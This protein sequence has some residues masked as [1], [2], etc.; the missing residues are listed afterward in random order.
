MRKYK[1]IQLM[2]LLTATLFI[3]QLEAQKGYAWKKLGGG[4]NNGAGCG[5]SSQIQ[6]TKYINGNLYV[7]EYT[8]QTGKVTI[9]KWNGTSWSKYPEFGFVGAYYYIKDIE[10]YNNDLYLCGDI[11]SL[12]GTKRAK[13]KNF[14]IVKFNGTNWDSLSSYYNNVID[15]VS[16]YS[17]MKVYKSKLYYI[18][19]DFQNGFKN[20][21]LVSFD[22]LTNT[23]SLVK[24]VRNTNK[25]FY[26][27]SHLEVVKNKLM[28][29]GAFDSI[30]GGV[31]TSSIFYYDGTNYSYTRNKD[32]RDI[33]RI[34]M[35]N[36]SQYVVVNSYNNKVEIW[37]D[38][39]LLKDIT[40]PIV[41]FYYYNGFTF[42]NN[43]IIAASNSVG[44]Y[45]YDLD[46]SK[47]FLNQSLNQ[48]FNLLP[49]YTYKNKALIVSCGNGFDG[50][51]EI[52]L[53]A[54]ISGKLYVDKDSSCTFNTG[55]IL[56]KHSLVEFDNGSQKFYTY[57]DKN[58]NYEI[59]LLA[60]SYNVSYS[61]PDVVST[62]A[63][64]SSISITVV[65]GTTTTNLGI[66]IHPS[67]NKNLGVA[68]SAYRGYRTRLGFT[69]KYTLTGTNFSL[70]N[71]S[72]VM[73]LKYPSS[74]TYV[75]SDV[76][77]FSNSSNEL[78]YKFANLAWLDKK[79]I[80]IEFKTTVGV[81]SLG[82]KLGFFASI[83]NGNG[84]SVPEN[85]VDTLVQTVVG[86]YD[87]NIKQCYPE[88]KVKPGLKKIKYTIHF[89]NTGNDTAY[90][91]TVVDTFT[92]K[93]GLRSLKVTNTSH[94]SSYSL[95]LGD[96]NTLIWEFNNIL[97][98]D[99]HINEKASHGFISFEANIN[100]VVALGDS[101]TNKAYIYFDY[102]TPIK[103]NVASVV[104]FNENTSVQ[105]NILQHNEFIKV[106][107]NPSFSNIN[108]IVDTKY[109]NKNVQLYNAMGQLINSTFVNDKGESQFNVSEL[110]HGIYF[111]KVEG[112]E[113]SAKL[114]VQ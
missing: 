50:A 66:P 61:L 28:I 13:N 2:L 15:S 11:S 32:R 81:S 85:N 26:T 87:P 5:S 57:S 31:R 45:Y 3:Q 79:I 99:S 49:V 35:R 34:A 22:A 97:L 21:Y 83:V 107:P 110:P 27:F 113:I 96:D 33:Y 55:D 16:T 38:D 1:I 48:M 14:H 92:Q 25:N 24:T 4:I 104:I 91:V 6:A 78:V 23:S 10:V 60:G 44:N 111:I 100:G 30:S 86:A 8:Q 18:L 46:S 43:F 82:D 90:K 112:T 94:P 102:Q 19:N 80:T 39:S 73:K 12:N 71:D 76:A 40:N 63:P 17:K 84:D 101:I 9:H 72:L 20:E 36:D 41:Q 53:G 108:I 29:S 64:C 88:G 7:T 59:S 54:I 62:M 65:A 105:E 70:I 77:P 68:I 51:A 42:Y 103:T 98:P 95:R 89:Q 37:Q 58:G 52:A 47:W 109:N 75:S 69:E 114:M 106:Y 74:A 93:L 67:T 56:L